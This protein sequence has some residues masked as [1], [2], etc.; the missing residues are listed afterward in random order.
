MWQDGLALLIVGIAVLVLVRT[1]APVG[2]LR[3]GTRGKDN[4]SAASSAAPTGCSGCGLGASCSKV[5]VKAYPVAIGRREQQ[6]PSSMDT[7]RKHPS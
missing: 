6:F 7:A 5:Q 2:W 3:F 4:G 1:Y